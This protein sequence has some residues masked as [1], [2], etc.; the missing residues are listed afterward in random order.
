MLVRLL[1]S[2]FFASGLLILASSTTVYA[3]LPTSI[4]YTAEAIEAKL[5]AMQKAE[6]RE[7]EARN[8]LLLQLNLVFQGARNS[9]QTDGYLKAAKAYLAGTDDAELRAAYGAAL[10][11]K[12][13]LH[14]GDAAIANYWFS[15]GVRQMDRAVRSAPADLA[16]R[17]YRGM[18]YLASPKFLQKREIAVEDLSC[19]YN[20]EEIDV[21]GEGFRKFIAE[22]LLAALLSVDRQQE[23]EALRAELK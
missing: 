21:L 17:L 7:V 15:Q 3:A 8:I 14:A 1:V 11:Y 22:N 4:P 23:A 13:S 12:A 5:A 19:V 10:A 16:P 6:A 20:S 2:G 9:E 18:A